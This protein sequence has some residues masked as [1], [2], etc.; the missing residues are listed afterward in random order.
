MTR[1]AATHLRLASGIAVAALVIP[2]ALAFAQEMPAVPPAVPEIPKATLPA[3]ES[4]SEMPVDI[5]PI[6]PAGE[7]SG[8]PRSLLPAGEKPPDM[9]APPPVAR[10]NAGTPVQVGELSALEGPLAGTMDD[11]NGGLGVNEWQGSSRATVVTMVQSAPAS[12]PSATQRLLMRKLLLSVAPPPP[13]P[14]NGS[15]NKVRLDRLLDGGYLDDAAR[16]ALRVQVPNNPELLRTQTDALLYAG[17]DNDACSDITAT[18][19]T[20]RSRSGSNCAPIATR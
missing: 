12:T 1:N 3:D 15:F 20:A 7:A 13:G 18:G 5:A 16:L 8:M 4:R 9:P 6:A 19:W 14:A 11:S 2:C 10:A 17:R